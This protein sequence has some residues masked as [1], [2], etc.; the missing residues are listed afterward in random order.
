MHFH[1]DLFCGSSW[2]RFKVNG[3][4]AGVAENDWKWMK[5]LTIRPKKRLLETKLL[6][7][8]QLFFSKFI[9]KLSHY[10][11]K[12]S[13]EITVED[14]ILPNFPLQRHTIRMLEKL[15]KTFW[16]RAKITGFISSNWSTREFLGQKSV[17]WL[18]CDF[19]NSRCDYQGE[20]HDNIMRTGPPSMQT[21]RSLRPNNA[22][23]VKSER[24]DL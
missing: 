18:R 20:H 5:S 1:T 15:L 21:N 22:T 11:I 3:D 24:V 19:F 16:F 7:G 13:M 8:K 9:L 2:C 4:A 14:F 17:S 12:C 6:I 23:R 10:A